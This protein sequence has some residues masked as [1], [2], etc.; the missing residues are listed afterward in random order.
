M[1]TLFDKIV[2]IN[3]TKGEIADA[4]REQGVEVPENTCFSEYP[5]LIKSIEGGKV[6]SVNGQTGDVVLTPQDL[7][8][9][10]ITDEEILSLGK[11]NNEET[12]EITND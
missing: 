6:D 10:P 3:E 12:T 5:N 11:T 9:F 8:M 2:S 4:I 7:W 1:S